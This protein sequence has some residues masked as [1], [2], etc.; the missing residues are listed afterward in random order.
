M[1]DICDLTNEI[2]ILHS[3]IG[4]AY[5]ST[6]CDS[7][8]T[9]LKV[10]LDL[11]SSVMGCLRRKKSFSDSDLETIMNISKKYAEISKSKNTEIF[12]LPIGSESIS[13]LSVCRAMS[14]KISR[15]Y[16]KLYFKEINKDKNIMDFI[17]QL[18]NLFYYMGIAINCD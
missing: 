17:G 13:R 8:R 9:D 5:E 10:I 2:D 14:K 16:L 6:R 11:I 12:H 4:L 7:L 15:M 3:H 1:T 18:S